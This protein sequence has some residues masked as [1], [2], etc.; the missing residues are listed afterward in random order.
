MI[1]VLAQ[2]EKLIIS[3]LRELLIHHGLVT[4]SMLET[5]ILWNP[6]LCLLQLGCILLVLSRWENSWCVLVTTRNSHWDALSHLAR[7][8]QGIPKALLPCFVMINIKPDTFTECRTHVKKRYL[9]WKAIR[10]G[11]VLAHVFP[12]S[13]VHTILHC[14]R[15]NTLRLYS[16]YVSDFAP[17]SERIVVHVL[18]VDVSKAD[19]RILK[20]LLVLSHLKVLLIKWYA[21]F[22]CRPQSLC[23]FY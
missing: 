20:L 3:H 16:L 6:C 13:L 1:F 8:C 21:N 10:F 9:I 15:R 4:W 19:H 23:L 22:S 5:W 14:R 11:R 18:L 7:Q 12:Y 17:R 2:V